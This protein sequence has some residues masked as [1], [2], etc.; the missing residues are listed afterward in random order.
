MIR[1]LTGNRIKKN[2]TFVD[3]KDTNDGLQKGIQYYLS[4]NI[5]AEKR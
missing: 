2:G 5:K 1:S 3:I 4:T